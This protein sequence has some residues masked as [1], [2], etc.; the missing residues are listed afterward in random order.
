VRRMK[1][2]LINALTIGAIAA[3]AFGTIVARPWW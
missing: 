3:M 1:A 2:K